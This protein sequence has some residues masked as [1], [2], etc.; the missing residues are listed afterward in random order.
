MTL[1]ITVRKP[2]LSR[3]VYVISDVLTLF[4]KKEKPMSKE[5]KVSPVAIISLTDFLL[6]NYSHIYDTVIQGIDLTQKT[7]TNSKLTAEA[8]FDLLR[9]TGAYMQA[10]EN[11]GVL[12]GLEKKKAV[13]EYIVKE[14]LETKAEIKE[15]WAGWQDTLSW[16]I[17]QVIAVFNSG[18]NVLH[19]FKN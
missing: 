3:A 12:K 10:V 14:Y 17:D 1:H 9:T 6:K 19:A 16:Y 8:V 13:F 2:W 15:V 7:Y 5:I 11:E 18:H 4:L